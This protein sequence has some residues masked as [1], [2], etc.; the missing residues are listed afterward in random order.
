MQTFHTIDRLR[1]RALGALFLTG[2]GALWLALGLFVRRQL[3]LA[4]LCWISGFTL[5]LAAAAVHVMRRARSA[6]RR[7]QD[8]TRDRA[9]Y[10]INAA[11]W[12]AVFVALNILHRMRLDAYGLNLIAAV[13]GLHFFPL[14]R[15]FRNPLHHITGALLLAWSALTL[16]KVPADS[17]QGISALGAGFL[18]WLSAATTLALCALALRRAP[19]ALRSRAA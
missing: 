1:G 8:A 15:L 2:F 5:V 4:A 9:F 13:V 6:P 18:L 10:W 12:I 19:V 7:P 16:W 11:Q 3:D 17:L 14:A